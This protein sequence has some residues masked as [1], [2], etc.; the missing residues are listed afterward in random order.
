MC[1]RG[2]PSVLRRESESGAS[3][4]LWYD[5]VMTAHASIT[6]GKYRL[7]VADYEMLSCAGAFGDRRTELIEGDVI[8]MSP[9]YRPH[10][11]IKMEL[12]DRLR[13]LLRASGSVLRPVIEFSLALADDSMP[14]PDIMLTTQPRGEKAVPLSSVALVIKVS[15]TTLASDLGAKARLY[16]RHGIPEYW[17]ADVNARIIHQMWA[18]VDGAFAERR[19]VIFGEPLAA[20]TVT[21]LQV[22]TTDL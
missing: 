10:G 22:E 3:I 7:R 6:P 8:V 20:A 21:G 16:A 15:D 11:M 4:V 5:I 2:P 1:R 18:P 13:D 17:V 14:D 9:Q 12:Y 19:D